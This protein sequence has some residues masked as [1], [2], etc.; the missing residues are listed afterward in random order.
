L[1]NFKQETS[2]PNGAL[3][4]WTLD[5]RL[6]LVEWCELQF[7][8]T[9]R[10]IRLNLSGHGLAG[11]I[12]SSPGNLSHLELLNQLQHLSAISLAYNLLQGFI[13]DLALTN[14]S[15]LAY[16]FLSGNKLTGTIPP[17]IGSLSK[18]KS[19]EAFP[20]KPHGDHP[21]TPRKHN[22]FSETQ[23]C[24]ESTARNNS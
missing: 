11:Q 15:N 14:C 1:L 22:H 12:S 8:A 5:T 23:S 17:S 3:R 16:L 4:N 2:D 13:S 24:R 10:V 6:L 21:I 9:F 20:D 7:D 19:F 18:L